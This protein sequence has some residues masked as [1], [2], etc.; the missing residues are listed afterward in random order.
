MQA[1]DGGTA[2]QAAQQATHRRDVTAWVT[3][4]AVALMWTLPFLQPSHYFPLPSFYSEWLAFALGLAALALLA[5][6]RAWAG[7]TLPVVACAPGA[8]AALILAQAVY[9]R[10]PYAGQ[11]LM[12]AYYLLWCA[13]LIVLG[14]VLR[15]RLGLRASVTALACALGLAGLAT[16]AMGLLQYAGYGA[17]YGALVLP[18]TGEIYGNLA[19]RNQYAD[20]LCLALASVA[21]LYAS[22]RLRGALASAA[23]AI[24]VAGLGVSASRGAWLYLLAL[25]ALAG[26]FRYSARSAASLRML[27]FM[28]AVLI[29]F[30][31]DQAVMTALSMRDTTVDR[32]FSGEGLAQRLHIL[33]SAWDMYTA[34]PLLGAGWE[35]YPWLHFEARAALDRPLPLGVTHNAHN[36]PLHLLAETGMLGA[37][38][39]VGPALVWWRDLWRAARDSEWSWLLMLA[40][41]LALHSMVEFP[42]WQSYFLGVAAIV[43]GLGSG[44]V[45]RLPLQRYAPVGVAAVLL[46]GACNAAAL[47]YEYGRF[48]RLTLQAQRER[49][50]A[51]EG[52]RALAEREPVLRPYVELA[53]SNHMPLD[54]H[55]LGE[56]LDT[57][58][59]VLAFFPAPM[60]V[61]RHA[62]LLAL[63]GDAPAAQRLFTRAAR[64]YPEAV[65][66]ARAAME[67]L[68]PAYPAQ[69][70][71]LLELASA[72]IPSPAVP[73]P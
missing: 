6:R 10:V 59:R 7:G 45:V 61:F 31:V 38:L 3:L 1:R 2:T 29:G 18:A 47:A 71:P 51:L 27:K 5:G 28:I 21:Y 32:V 58:A 50:A 43:I 16:A 57:N 37:L 67:R 62:V 69:I 56:K 72:K 23:A 64:V 65:A 63:S 40:A 54:T 15:R 26:C 53:V 60:V 70:R 11:A 13:A 73:A 36:L 34:Q 8:L 55:A 46:A 33:R 4:G 41:V 12:A 30:A 9:D 24:L 39:I 68:L 19:Q 48:E 25:C 14:G 35:R 52:L 66:Q 17:V 20:Y 22:G 49:V 44:R 42:L